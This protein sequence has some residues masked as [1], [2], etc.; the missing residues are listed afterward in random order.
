MH[1]GVHN[2]TMP[3]TRRIPLTHG[4][5]AIV[6]AAD[7]ERVSRFKWSALRDA[8]GSIWY[9]IRSFK[10]NDGKRSMQSMHRFLAGL[11]RGDRRVVD[12]LNRNGLDNR[13][14]NLLVC[15]PSENNKNRKKFRW[16]KRY[17]RDDA[18]HFIYRSPSE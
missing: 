10:S 9:A 8:G 14:K 1:G 16:M 13:R 6:D 15:T 18:P 4:K 12:H 3:K 7:Y 2:E 17:V 5:Y 11:R